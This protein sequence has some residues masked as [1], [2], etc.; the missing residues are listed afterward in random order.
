M[1]RILFIFL[2]GT[3]FSWA[4]DHT[5]EAPAPLV[6][7]NIQDAAKEGEPQA[8]FELGCLLS[9]GEFIPKNSK[10]AFRL[11]LES[12]KKGYSKAQYK[13]AVAYFNGEGVAKD[14]VEGLAWMKLA[15]A[16]GLSSSLLQSM[17]ATAGTK[18]CDTAKKRSQEIIGKM[19]KEVID[20]LNLKEKAQGGDPDIQYRLG[21]YYKNRKIEPMDLGEAVLQIAGIG[22]IS[23]E[24]IKSAVSLFRKSADQGYAPAENEL[25]NMYEINRVD[26][27]YDNK[28]HGHTADIKGRENALFWWAK[29]AV[30]GYPPAQ[31][32][33][34]GALQQGWMESVRTDKYIKENKLPSD[35]EEENDRIKDRTSAL[36]LFKKSA[37]QG[38]ALAQNNLGDC[39]L[40]GEVVQKDPAKAVSWY[41]KSAM[42]GNLWAQ[43]SLGDAYANGIG[44]DKNISEAIKWYEKA[45][46]QGDKRANLILAN[47]DQEGTEKPPQKPS[48]IPTPVV[49]PMGASPVY[50]RVSEAGPLADSSPAAKSSTQLTSEFTTPGV[51][52]LQIIHTR[53][54]S[55]NKGSKR[56]E[57]A[58]KSFRNELIDVPQVKVQVYFYDD[59]NGVIVPSMAQVTSS[60]SSPPVDWKNGE[61]EL[62][63]VRCLTE[64]ADPN[65]KFAGYLIAVYYKGDLQDCRADPPQLKR[66]FE[67]K[68]Y[69][70]SDE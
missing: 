26:N 54:D 2:L 30:Q 40:K 47:L 17:E 16:D 31:N 58:I 44:V 21:L 36:E 9:S 28:P 69:V 34:A 7:K 48:V 32:N 18:V 29:A 5:K 68:Y 59:N 3:N 60:W 4:D 70:A 49:K 41:K 63:E 35:A 24:D 37:E 55:S 8:E 23:N 62:L 50:T 19:P 42:Q 43:S 45:S 51:P 65:I 22:D 66:L 52:V 1:K 64:P 12:A 33:L 56:L 27:L 39:Y 6:M 57:V 38:F 46:A 15:V 14:Q 20:F 61:P 53:L 10:E 13:V 11:F 67:P 25:A